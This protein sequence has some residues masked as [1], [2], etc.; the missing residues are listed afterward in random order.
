MAGTM[1]LRAI[2][3]GIVLFGGWLGTVVGETREPSAR[4][5][6]VPP[7]VEAQTSGL[8]VWAQRLQAELL[9]GLS[10]HSWISLVERESLDLAL[11]ELE[12]SAASLSA[13]NALSLGRLTGAEYLL[14]FHCAA[15]GDAV[16]LY[17]RILNTWLGQVEFVQSTT[18]PQAEKEK[19]TEWAVATA[20]GALKTLA[21][22]EPPN[23]TFVA[24]PPFVNRSVFEQYDYLEETL[25]RA[26][27]EFLGRLSTVQVVER[28]KIE[29]LLKESE[30]HASGVV[31]QGTARDPGKPARL[32]LVEG[33]FEE[34]MEA[35]KVLGKG[36]AIKVTLTC[37]DL[38][39]VS[40]SC[41]IVA[42]GKMD[43]IPA[44]LTDIQAKVLGFLLSLNTS[45]VASAAAE[46]K[47][48]FQ[49]GVAFAMASDIYEKLGVH[50]WQMFSGLEK[51]SSPT[52]SVRPAGGRGDPRES[53]NVANAL[54]EFRLALFLDPSFHA[55][56]G[57]LGSVLM[58]SRFRQKYPEAITCF[59]TVY[60][61]ARDPDMQRYALEA[62][63]E[64]Y[65]RL[66][67]F[68]QEIRTWRMYLQEFCPE[69][70]GNVIPYA[71]IYLAFHGQQ[72]WTN[73]LAWVRRWIAAAA[74]DKKVQFWPQ[75][76]PYWKLGLKKE[77][78]TD[79]A[80]LAANRPDLL[81]VCYDY[82][83][84]FGSAGKEES[85]IRTAI[86][87][88][89]KEVEG[90]AS[91][92]PYGY[93]F[94]GIC[95]LDLHQPSEA[96]PWLEKATKL[97]GG[98]PF[99]AR[100]E[101]KEFYQNQFECDL[102]RA[103]ED[104]GRRK[105][106]L[107]VYEQ[108]LQQHHKGESF[109]AEMLE[110]AARAAASVSDWERSER[111]YR[112]LIELFYGDMGNEKEI[113]AEWRRVR[114]KAGGSET[115]G[116]GI[117]P[118]RWEHITDR[119][120]LPGARGVDIKA[121][122]KNVWFACAPAQKRTSGSGIACL[123]KRSKKVRSYPMACDVRAIACGRTAIWVG[124]DSGLQR[125]DR[126]NGQW[127][128]YRTK[129]GLPHDAVTCLQ[130]DGDQLWI[131]LGTE[132]GGEYSRGALALMDTQKETFSWFSSSPN[133][134]E[135]NAGPPR[136]AVKSI[137]V[138]TADVWV[139]VMGT[140]LFRY[141]R[142]GNSWSVYKSPADPENLLSCVAVHGDSLWIGHYYYSS[143]YRGGV[144]CYDI[145]RNVW[146]VFRLANGLLANDV[147]ALCAGREYVWFGAT[148]PPE[149]SEVSRY[150]P[151]KKTFK[152]ITTADGLLHNE[153]NC[154]FEDQDDVWFGTEAGA[155]CL[156][157]GARA[158]R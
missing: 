37:K 83:Y 39:K 93:G 97:C 157:G 129:E 152:G 26:L 86:E 13:E 116:Q 56:R 63:A 3:L 94:V 130:I 120:G 52:V 132:G 15:E 20:T 158:E 89:K 80:S 33:Y 72:D 109:Y 1:K 46:A 119:D 50:T 22:R 18:S 17:L 45:Y 146:S 38:S 91:P 101:F 107:A 154:I 59:E 118:A 30:L 113:V 99:S 77:F 74:A 8:Q 142:K 14:A 49:R 65:H 58:D 141:D 105:E 138:S 111:H 6:I 148:N 7:T 151:R 66:E 140:G 114:G 106:A 76:G 44:L 34:V 115:T 133:S 84:R 81:P 143:C 108:F 100:N 96:I 4:T 27:R 149:L 23:K 36:A 102:G 19:L 123:G 112:T 79:M 57:A 48:H 145:G 121:D 9:L 51:G 54:Q 136:H 60:H 68:D 122:T 40:S 127:K 75:E 139:T 95:H 47:R 125:L 35:G 31:D 43:E 78:L 124:T 137:A 98:G 150:D 104:V 24:V 67:K 28:K 62:A 11:K 2:I 87:V 61:N 156:R 85:L 69:G 144:A 10:R 88:L 12:L 5:L 71:R 134:L 90:S 131:G 53:K 147:H 103:Y 73:A 16:R 41:D 82:I 32:V 55:A 155:S 21:A 135:K 117:P 92:Y 153:V 42:I 126:A 110:G 70:Q 128:V 29:A 25:S 64:G